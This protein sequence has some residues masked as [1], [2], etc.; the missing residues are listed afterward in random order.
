LE[1][2]NTSTVLKKKKI[3]VYTSLTDTGNSL[4]RN[5]VRQRQVPLDIPKY[6]VVIGDYVY[7][8]IV[9]VIGD[10]VYKQNNN[11][12]C[13]IGQGSKCAEAAKL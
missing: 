7:K 11:H 2:L 1:K 10:Y 9:V 12:I 4:T 3:Q 6:Y 13:R 5:H 8:Q